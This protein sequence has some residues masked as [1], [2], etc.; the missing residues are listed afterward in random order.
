MLGVVVVLPYGGVGGSGGRLCGGGLA[1]LRGDA[2]EGDGLWKG[3]VGFQAF[4]ERLDGFWEVVLLG[5]KCPEKGA[6]ASP[7]LAAF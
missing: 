3:G 7:I 6:S 2:W 5:A 1:S 4:G